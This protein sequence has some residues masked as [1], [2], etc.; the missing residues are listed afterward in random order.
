MKK[1]II[2]CLFLMI[3]LFAIINPVYARTIASCGKTIKGAII[4][5]KIV[6][7]VSTV[8]T[9]IKIAVPVLLVIF[10]SLDLAKGVIAGKEDEIKKGQQMFIKRL[11]AGALVFFVFSIVQLVMSLVSDNKVENNNI[12]TCVN[13]FLNKNCSYCNDGFHVS[14]DGTYCVQN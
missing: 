14:E 1:K 7:V 3:G 11:I 5:E 4:D 6:N 13:C 8:V 10:G 12:M 9:I 2:F